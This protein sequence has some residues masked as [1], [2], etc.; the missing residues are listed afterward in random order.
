M[1]LSRSASKGRKRRVFSSYSLLAPAA[2][3]RVRTTQLKNLRFA[4]SASSRLN[5]RV[6]DEAASPF[7]SVSA[8]TRGLVHYDQ[9]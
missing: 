7:E 2:L 3:A 4:P 1:T 9:P 5:F 6:V 8:G